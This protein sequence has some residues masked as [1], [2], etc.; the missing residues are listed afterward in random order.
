MMGSIKVADAYDANLEL[1]KSGDIRILQP[2]FNIYGK[3]RAFSGP[4]FTLKALEHNVGV[5]ELLETKGEGRVLFIDGGGS[6]RI[7][8]VGEYLC[9][10]AQKSG[11]AGIVVNG[12]IR[13]V[14]EI[15]DG[16]D[17]GVRALASH[18]GKPGKKGTAEEHVPIHVGGTV[19]HDGEWLYADGDGILVSKTRLSL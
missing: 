8:L 1:A 11:W 5:K 14:D 19:I 10:L 15:N 9:S 17:I 6:M 13:D 18:P 7:A 12:C 4:I 3:C 2:I 16:C